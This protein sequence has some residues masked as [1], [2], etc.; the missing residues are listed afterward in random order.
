M[1]SYIF[2]NYIFRKRP[3]I[4]LATITDLFLQ[5]YWEATVLVIL[6]SLTISVTYD[7]YC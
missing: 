2:Q 5:I 7:L 1:A 4:P 3:N 6:I